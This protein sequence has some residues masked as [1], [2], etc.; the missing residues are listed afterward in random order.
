MLG[1][2]CALGSPQNGHNPK[3]ATSSLPSLGAEARL[4]HKLYVVTCPHI[5]RQNQKRLHHPCLLGGPWWGP[6]WN[7]SVTPMCRGSPKILDKTTTGYQPSHG[8]KRGPNGSATSTNR[9]SPKKGTKPEWA[10]SPPPSPGPKNRHN[11]FVTLVILGVPNKGDE[12]KNSRI[13]RTFSTAHKWAEWLRN[14]GVGG[15]TTKDKMGNGCITCTF[16]GAQK[17]AEWLHHPCVL[18][19]PLEKGT[20][21]EMATLPLPSRGPTSGQ[22]LLRNL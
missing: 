10:T 5:R 3:M 12:T 9:G 2:P 13:T 4:L 7:C 21:S 8:P 16:S 18:G 15:G 19:A 20:K 11:C 17:W 6:R 14:P 1:N 22:E